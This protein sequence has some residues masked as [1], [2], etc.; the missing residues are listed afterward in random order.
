MKRRRSITVRIAVWF[1]FILVVLVLLT[2]LVFRIVSASIL[3]KTVRGY[4]MG[5]VNENSDKIGYLTDAQ[6][7]QNTDRDNVYIQYGDGWLEIDDDYLDVIDDV[8]TALYTSDGRMLYGKNPISREMEGEEFTG[9]RVYR[10]RAGDNTR[11]YVY[12]RKLTGEGKTDLWLRGVV[13]LSAEEMQLVDI[14]HTAIFFFPVLI[15]IGIAGSWIT[16]RRGLMP[17]RRIEQTAMSITKETDLARRIRLDDLDTELFDLGVA[18]NGMLDRL[19]HAFATEQQFTSDASHEL[20]TPMTVIQAQTELA[21]EQER[22]PEE[23]RRALQVIRRQSG[24]MNA[25]ITSML[26]YTRLEMRPENYPLEPMDLT[27]TIRA[28]VADLEIMK[29]PDLELT[30][31]IEDGIRIQG[32]LIL[33]ERAV[34]N[35]L[36][37]ARKYGGPVPAIHVA[38]G[39]EINRQTKATEAVCAVTDHGPGISRDEQER[40]FE[41][42]Y[43]A[44]PSR[45]SVKGIPGA[46]LGLSMVRKIMDLHGGRVTLESAPG[47]GSTFR[48]HFPVSEES[49]DTN[50]SVD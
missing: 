50:E 1:T 39:M 26:D 19:E 6:R 47:Q 43:R 14:F 34:Q 48:L 11:Y 25:L 3:Q 16:A 45:S 35:V 30:T 27:Q 41:R 28:C 31:A 24:R 38:L 12:D 10:Y 42:F 40:I 5:S 46:G 15:I 49:G 9:T 20:R 37:N 7:Q 23:Y 18:F 29:G 4:L 17:V 2:Y 33:V 32:N 8:Q 22:S 13:S 21:L 36:D 44:D